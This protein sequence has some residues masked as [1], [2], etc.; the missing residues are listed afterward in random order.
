MDD[1][2]YHLSENLTPGQAD[3]SRLLGEYYG[4]RLQNEVIAQ[5]EKDLKKLFS[6]RIV[7]KAVELDSS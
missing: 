4:Y 3:L 7:N 1:K 5:L 6:E 2:N